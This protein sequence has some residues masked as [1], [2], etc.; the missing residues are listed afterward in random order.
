MAM[1]LKFDD[2]ARRRN[3]NLDWN[4]KNPDPDSQTSKNSGYCSEMKEWRNWGTNY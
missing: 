2:V 4:W 1:L 3:S